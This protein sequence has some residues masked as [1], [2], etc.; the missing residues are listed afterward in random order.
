M[1]RKKKSQLQMLTVVF[2]ALIV[3]VG[4]V[5][6]GVYKIKA[7]GGALIGK[8]L[9]SIVLTPDFTD[10]ELDVNKDYTFTIVGSPDGVKLEELEFIV[11]SSSVSFEA[12]GDGVAVL[13]TYGEGDIKLCVRQGDVDSN[14][15]GFKITDFAAVE[16]AAAAEAEAAAQAAKE[17][18]EAEIAKQEAQAASEA[19][20]GYVKA[21]DKVRIR[22]TP[23][24]EYN[25]NIIDTC[26]VGDIFKR[27]GLE[28]DWSKIEYKDNTA[29]IKTEFLTE[30]TEEEA[31]AAKD[32]NTEAVAAAVEATTGQSLNDDQAAA[33]A[34]AVAGAQAQQAA[35]AQAQQAQQAADA[36]ALAD[37]QAALEAQ[38]ATAAAAT[39]A[40]GTPIHCKDGTCYVTA[41]QLQTIHATWDFAGDAIEMAG[42]H[43]IGEL[44]AV[45]GPTVH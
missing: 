32:K 13:H 9:E 2:A 14:T 11:D 3:V 27:L 15:L 31:E 35:D 8:K 34:A 42:H 12:G 23:S 29:Y 19:A 30:I 44:E 24:T 17:A 10:T 33:V 1:K 26:A 37:A 18:E 4:V 20:V 28:G 41:A 6:L 40:M 36:Q 21:N 5:L 25:D 45:I 39:A 16:A 38:A 7:N 43:N 22:K